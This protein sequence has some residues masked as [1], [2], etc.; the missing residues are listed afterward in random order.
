MRGTPES[1]SFADDQYYVSV[2]SINAVWEETKHFLWGTTRADRGAQHCGIGTPRLA[3]G[4]YVWRQCDLPIEMSIFRW[5]DSDPKGSLFISPIHGSGKRTVQHRCR[6]QETQMKNCPI[7]AKDYNEQMGACDQCNS[8][9][10][11]WYMA[12]V[13]FGKDILDIDSFIYFNA[14]TKQKL[15]QKEYF[16]SVINSIV[17]RSCSHIDRTLF[18]LAVA[19]GSSFLSPSRKR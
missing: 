9:R 8:H 14:L 5:R 16:L 4:E 6:G 17:A 18:S 10:H 2:D 7:C 13:Y 12:A 3:N 1:R 15:S 19:P 11:R